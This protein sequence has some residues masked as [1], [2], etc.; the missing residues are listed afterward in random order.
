MHFD[1]HVLQDTWWHL[2]A[3]PVNARGTLDSMLTDRQATQGGCRNAAPTMQHHG[4]TAAGSWPHLSTK[5]P[6]ARGSG[7]ARSRSPA[8]ICALAAACAL[9]TAALLSAKPRAFSTS[10]RER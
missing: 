10:V 2:S 1:S 3:V 8:A 7:V 5:T 4:L 9:L 6:L